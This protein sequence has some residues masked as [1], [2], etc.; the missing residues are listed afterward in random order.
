MAM[1]HIVLLRFNDTCAA[2]RIAELAQAFAAL[3]SSIA[4]ITAFEAG[5]NVS[6]EGLG[7]GFTHA[8]VMTF[9]DAAARDAYLPHAQHQAFVEQLKPCLADVLV[10]DYE[11]TTEK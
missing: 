7:H 10:F 5:E 3:P 4:G 11:L 2:S 1:Q 6:P 8:F 9:V